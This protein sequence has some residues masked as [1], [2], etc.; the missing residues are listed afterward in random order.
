MLAQAGYEIIEKQSRSTWLDDSI[1]ATG[2]IARTNDF[3]KGFPNHY[4]EVEGEME[5]DLRRDVLNALFDLETSARGADY[6][7]AARLYKLAAEQGHAGAA[8]AEAAS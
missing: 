1:L 3:E 4:S 7:E 8:P 5:R 6:L 2:E